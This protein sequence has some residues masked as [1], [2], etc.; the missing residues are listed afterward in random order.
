VNTIARNQGWIGGRT[1][2]LCFFFGSAALAVTLGVWMLSAPGVVLPLWF[3]WIWLLEGPHLVAT[4]QR[5]YLDP[6]FRRQHAKLLWASLL[7][8]LPG[9][10]LLGLSLWLGRPEV[11]LLFLGLAALWS[12][13]HA[14]RQYHGL[15][16]IYQRLNTAAVRDRDLDRRLLYA[17]LWGSFGLF[18]LMHP[19]NRVLWMLAPEPS[20]MARA[21]I[22]ALAAALLAT[23]LWW[24]FLLV[25]RWRAQRTLKPGL[26]ALVVA[27][28]TTLFATF[29]VGLREPL[30]ARAVTVE[31]IF[32]AATA[33]SGIV[34][35]VHYL[36][37]VIATGKRREAVGWSARVGRLPLLAY[38]LMVLV[39]LAYVG[40]NLLRGMPYGLAPSSFT[41]QLFM[42]LYWG[43][44][45]HHFWLD[46]KIWRPS[47]DARLRSEL[48]LNA[49]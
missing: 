44:F 21:L 22:A 10:L 28:G 34:H 40:L 4:W 19:A 29:V 38:G 33:V 49:P 35:G 27:V 41:A 1:F 31:E 5:S 18:Q 16:S 8:L 43:V 11:F 12:Y 25:Q 46:Q 7:W 32:M 20:E 24:A 9:P 15:L 26:F 13:H 47:S 48:G 6:Q 14:V 23:I 45:L 36:G 17:V 39:S 30:F 2:D 3:L 42:A 37:V